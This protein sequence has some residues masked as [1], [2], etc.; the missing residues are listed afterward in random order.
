MKGCRTVLRPFETHPP[1]APQ[2]EG[3]PLIELRKF[4]IL[5]RPRRRPSQRT[6]GF[7]PA[8]SNFLPSLVAKLIA[9]TPAPCKRRSNSVASTADHRPRSHGPI[10][11]PAQGD[12][13][14]RRRAAGERQLDRPCGVSASPSPASSSRAARLNRGSSAARPRDC[15]TGP[16]KTARAGPA[17]PVPPALS[18]RDQASP[19]PSIAISHRS[20]A[21]MPRRV[22]YEYGNC[23]IIYGQC[24]EVYRRGTETRS[25]HRAMRRS[26][27]E[28]CRSA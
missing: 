13:N 17:P 10:A 8:D 18:G 4:L 22:Q 20:R 24:F 23:V 12:R 16:W 19:T 14:L 11:S 2:D 25:S 26:P 6:H 9:S 7:D 1:C 15:P 3:R 28:A 5:R 21:P 27:L